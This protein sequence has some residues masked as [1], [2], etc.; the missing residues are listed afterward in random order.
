MVPAASTAEVAADGMVVVVMVVVM[1]VVV[2]VA[3]GAG[4]VGAGLGDVEYSVVCDGDVDNTVD[5]RGGSAVAS[6]PSPM[7][8]GWILN[9]SIGGDGLGFGR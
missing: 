4:N 3:R 8:L 2:V 6:L 5:G 1:V 7:F 9:G